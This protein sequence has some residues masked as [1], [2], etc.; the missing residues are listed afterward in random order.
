MAFSSLMSIIAYEINPSFFVTA[1]YGGYY[2]VVSP[3]LGF[4]H[5]SA[6]KIRPSWFLAE[7]SYLGFYLGISFSFIYYYL[8]KHISNNKL[9]LI[10]ILYL[11]SCFL[12]QSN[13]LYLAFIASII[14]CLVNNSVFKINNST[15][16]GILVIIIS[17][18]LTI[19]PNMDFYNLYIEYKAAQESSLDDRQNR[20]YS[21]FYIISEM[22]CLDF[23]LGLGNEYVT[24]ILGK[25]ESNVYYKLLCEQGFIFLLFFLFYIWK[26]LKYSLYTLTFA[27]IAFNATIVHL[28]PLTF[29]C[30]SAMLFFFKNKYDSSY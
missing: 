12:I 5:I 23:I 9:K 26:Y 28:T 3:L 16:F 2:T 24:N 22:K 21:T 29:L 17:I 30:F 6:D 11:I 13:T 8:K 10:T 20:M 19:I 18:I 15:I 25:G 4:L 1:G 14:I 27:L 7:P